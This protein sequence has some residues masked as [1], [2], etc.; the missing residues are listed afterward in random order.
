MS[1]ELILISYDEQQQPYVTG[2]DLHEKLQ[3][4]TPYMKW[5]QR[6]CEYDFIEGRDFWTFLSK[7]TGGRPGTDHRLSIDMAKQIC[8]LQRT[9]LGKT[10][11]EYFLELEK[12]WNSPEAV[13][14]RA[15]KFSEMTIAKL[16][17]QNTVLL[18]ANKAQARLIAKMEPESKYYQKVLRCQN[19]IPINIIAKDYGMSAKKMNKLL[20]EMK[21]QYK[22]TKDTWVLYQ[23]LA[24]KGYTKTDTY[25]DDYGSAHVH[26]KWTQAG[27]EFIYKTLKKDGVI[28]IY[29]K[30]GID[31]T[32]D[33]D[34]NYVDEPF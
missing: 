30:T 3:I 1:N 21:I 20:H 27:R 26:T 10:Y 7:S 33:E 28:P 29:D 15:L 13:M 22:A 18:E 14:A 6:M 4:E 19:A 17:S 31:P 25:Y 2:S 5:F 12:E 34:I 9:E 16:T 8:M 11:R 32:G 24:D 23:N